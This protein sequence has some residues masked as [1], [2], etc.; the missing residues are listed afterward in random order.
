MLQTAL[1]NHF[2][3]I[4]GVEV[5]PGQAD[6][7]RGSEEDRPLQVEAPIAATEVHPGAAQA[8]AEDLQTAEWIETTR[9]G[10]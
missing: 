2:L 8:G 9:A 4:N 5:D 10:T 1:A 6:H 3:R 7:R